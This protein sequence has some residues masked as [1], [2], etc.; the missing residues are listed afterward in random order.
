LAK[1]KSVVNNEV[2]THGIFGI[3]IA[4]AHSRL[5]DMFYLGREA[6]LRNH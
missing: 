2:Q 6:V 4:L 3:S 5:V 1:E